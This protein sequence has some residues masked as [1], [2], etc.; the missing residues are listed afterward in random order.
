MCLKRIGLSMLNLFE[1]NNLYIGRLGYVT[2]NKSRI[3]INKDENIFIIYRK[4]K[5]GSWGDYVGEDIF[6]GKE[7]FFWS[8]NKYDSD[9]ILRAIGNYAIRTSF[10][11]EQYLD[12]PM[13]YMRKDDLLQIYNHING[14]KIES[15]TNE[16]KLET[17]K[18]DKVDITDSIFKTI[19]ETAEMLKDNMMDES[20]KEGFRRELGELAGYYVEQITGL[21][22]D[23]FLQGKSEYSIR[24]EVIKSLAE[25]ETRINDPSIKR[26]NQ[27]IRE[28]DALRQQLTGK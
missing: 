20:L 27:L 8:G 18:K 24:M 17:S 9:T 23:E 28:Y 21:K 10:P 12:T 16:K 26:N 4:K 25:I 2:G 3:Y 11:L 14:K 7:Y 1:T 5:F 22:N 19:L 13:K 15:P 6:T